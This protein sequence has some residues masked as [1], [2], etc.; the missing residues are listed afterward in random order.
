M[1]A[2]PEPETHSVLAKA[3]TNF[4]AVVEYS[5]I[6]FVGYH[7][8]VCDPVYNFPNVNAG[9]DVTVWRIPEYG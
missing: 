4:V 3:F 7:K 5:Q 2:P 8:F 6:T 9:I 1:I